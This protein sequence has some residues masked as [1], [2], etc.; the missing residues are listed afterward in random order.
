MTKGDKYSGK[1]RRE[2]TTDIMGEDYSVKMAGESWKKEKYNKK[3]A[4]ES[5]MRFCPD[6]LL[7]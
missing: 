3:E 5:K 1:K 2:N 6:I 7:C 4:K